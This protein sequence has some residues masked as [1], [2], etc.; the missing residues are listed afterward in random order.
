MHER[1]ACA[2]LWGVSERGVCECDVWGV[3]ECDACM[4]VSGVHQCGRVLWQ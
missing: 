2:S 4:S 1:D 3:H